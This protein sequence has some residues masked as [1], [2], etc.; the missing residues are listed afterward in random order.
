MAV[1]EGLVSLKW[2]RWHG[3]LVRALATISDMEVDVEIAQ[4]SSRKP[5]S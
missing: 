5:G 3:S 4:P 1:A 2:F